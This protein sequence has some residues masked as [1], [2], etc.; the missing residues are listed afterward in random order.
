MVLAGALVFSYSWSDT[1]F[2]CND[3][4]L[5]ACDCHYS[6]IRDV[7]NLE[8]PLMAAQIMTNNRTLFPD[9]KSLESAADG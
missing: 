2:F 9:T 5:V 6:I 8:R 1:I 3:V 7:G 4:S